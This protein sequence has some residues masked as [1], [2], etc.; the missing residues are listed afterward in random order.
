MAHYCIVAAGTVANRTFAS[1]GGSAMCR[2]VRA[3][4]DRSRVRA[5]AVSAPRYT[6]PACPR[7]LRP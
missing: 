6:T 2:T 4:S 7:K 5:Q 3:A 1:G